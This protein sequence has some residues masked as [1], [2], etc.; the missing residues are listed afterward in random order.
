MQRRRR[1]PDAKYQKSYLIEITSDRTCKNSD[2][3]G[4]LYNILIKYEYLVERTTG[5]W[6]TKTINI[7]LHT[8]A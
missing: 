7:E 1:I 3:Q 4:I 8:G 6:K 2:E 5:N